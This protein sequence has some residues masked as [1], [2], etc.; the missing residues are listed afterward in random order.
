MYIIERDLKESSFSRLNFQIEN[1]VCGMMSAYRGS[2]QFTSSK[3][4]I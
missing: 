4:S 3:S 1:H 2:N